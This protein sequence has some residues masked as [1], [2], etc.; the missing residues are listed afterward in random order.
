MGRPLLRA[1]QNSARTSRRRRKAPAGE[2]HCR[3]AMADGADQQRL[4]VGIR[5][6]PMLN[7]LPR[8][9]G[10][11]SGRAAQQRAPV[12]RG[13]L[14]RRRE[15]FDDER[16]RPKRSAS[17]K[18]ARRRAARAV[19]GVA[20]VLVPCAAIRRSLPPGARNDARAARA[21]GKSAGGQRLQRVAFVDE[22]ERAAAIPPAREKIG[23]AI[24]DLRSAGKRRFAQATAPSTR[25]KAVTFAPAAAKYSALSPRPQP[26]SS[27]RRPS[28]PRELKVDEGFGERMGARLA[29][30]TRAAS[31]S[32]SA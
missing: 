21:C 25:S 12:A 32:A 2:H 9:E 16:A 26:T 4:R 5:K 22:I 30:G 19:L 10:A 15:V 1:A 8:R 11:P 3:R 28:R 24:V 6:M 7:A 20:R 27:T 23:G 18:I 29:Q 17:V 14:R 13:N 31:S